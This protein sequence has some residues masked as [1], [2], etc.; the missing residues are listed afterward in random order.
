M[1]LAA[2]QPNRFALALVNKRTGRMQLMPAEGGKVF[3]LEPKVTA[4]SYA[5]R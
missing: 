2:C 5:P 4:L 3:R 1:H